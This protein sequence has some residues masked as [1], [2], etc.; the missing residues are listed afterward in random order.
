M[1]SVLIKIYNTPPQ[2]SDSWLSVLHD[3]SITGD[4]LSL[5]WDLDGD[6]LSIVPINGV[7]IGYILVKQLIRLVKSKHDGNQR[8][9]A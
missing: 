2:V 3:Q 5:G 6:S 7:H 4:L 9:A 8:L 1:A